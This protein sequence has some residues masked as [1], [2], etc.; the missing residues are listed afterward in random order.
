[1]IKACN[2]SAPR[3]SQ[4]NI[5]KKRAQFTFP[6]PPSSSRISALQQLTRAIMKQSKEKQNPNTNI[7]RR[8]RDEILPGPAC[9]VVNLAITPYE[10]I[11]IMNKNVCSKRNLYYTSD[12]SAASLGLYCYY[13]ITKLYI[14]FI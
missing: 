12:P 1:M 5:T 6:S 2:S 11:P 8:A 10:Y 3:T 7:E 4:L 14:I 9:R 13:N